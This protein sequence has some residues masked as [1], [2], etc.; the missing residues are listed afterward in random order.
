MDMTIRINEYIRKDLLAY[1]SVKFDDKFRLDNI[2]LMRTQDGGVKIVLPEFQKGNE[3]ETHEIFHPVTREAREKLDIALLTAYS[4][5]ISKG[6]VETTLPDNSGDFSVSSVKSAIYEKNNIIG[7][8]TIYFSGSYALE[9]VRICEGQNGT[10]LNMPQ[11][12]HIVK[13]N[14]RTVYNLDGTAKTTYSD[15]FK[16]MSSDAYNHIYGAVMQSY[17]LQVMMYENAVNIMI[18]GTN[19]TRKLPNFLTSDISTEDLIASNIG[20]G[21]NFNTEKGM[22]SMSEQQYK[23]IRNV[24]LTENYHFVAQEKTKTAKSV[25]NAEKSQKSTRKSTRKDIADKKKQVERNK[26]QNAEINKT[27]EKNQS[28]EAR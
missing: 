14:G 1:A 19:E 25:E 12:K 4:N 18:E 21:V 8:A 10:F 2:R 23:A 6:E 27:K 15:I 28:K 3:A 20:D 22:F 13:E 16:P 5:T 11:L 9:G 24:I 7:L 17:N 26:Q